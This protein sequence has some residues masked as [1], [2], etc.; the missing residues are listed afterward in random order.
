MSKPKGGFLRHRRRGTHHRTTPG[1]NYYTDHREVTVAS[2]QV[3][4]RAQI[5]RTINTDGWQKELWDFYDTVGELRFATG[6]LANATSRCGLYIGT[7]SDSG[8]PHPAPDDE[9]DPAAATARDLLSAL[10]YGPIG[11]TE[12]LRRMTLHLSIPG[13]S[14]LIG[15]DPQPDAGI[16]DRRWYVASSDEIKVEMYGA[17]LTLPD[18]GQQVAL[19]EDNSS[20][21]RLWKPH[22]RRGW[23]PDSTLRAA[24]PVLREVKGLSDHIAATLD[25]RLAGAGI[26]VVPSEASMPAPSQSDGDGQLHEDPLTATLTEGML[27]PIADRDDASAVVP[28]VM[29]VPGETVDGVK[30]LRF[31]TELSANVTDMRTNALE[32]FAAAAD[33]P[34]E[35]VTGTSSMNHWGVAQLEDSAVK[36][37]VEPLVACICDALTQQYLWPALRAAGHTDVE[38]YVVWFSSA[39]LTQRPNKGPEAQ[40][41][42]DKGVLSDAALLRENGFSPDDAPTPVEHQRWLQERVFLANPSNTAVDLSAL[43]EEVPTATQTPD[44]PRELPTEPA[45]PTPDTTHALTAAPAAIEATTTGDPAVAWWLRA[46]EQA[47]LRALELS[48]K[49]ML[50]SLPRS[51]RHRTSPLRQVPTWEI[52]TKVRTPT[53]EDIERFMEGAFDTAHINFGNDDCVLSTIDEYCRDLLRSGTP[54]RREYLAGAL[55]RSGCAPVLEP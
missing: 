50:G 10:H 12:M 25:S 23:Q 31:D 16:T 15:M 3:V 33:L 2:A 37:Y 55:A 51:Y 30:H 11:Q 7:F 28:L 43:E 8:A 54:H 39:E 49:R 48:G 5:R 17:T 35:F 47:T 21:I 41:L 22:A 1:G 40:A 4:G 36:L 9:T 14:Y 24:L 34:K 53:D 42:W 45:Q 13:E 32:R 18:T 20:I 52:H 6:W 38:Q 44:Q 26:L 19:T 29:R 46:V 27:T